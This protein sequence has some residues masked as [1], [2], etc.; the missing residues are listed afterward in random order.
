MPVGRPNL[1]PRCFMTS[2]LAPFRSL[3]MLVVLA[4]M[5]AS[6]LE[7]AEPSTELVKQTV[8]TVGGEA[9][10]LKLFRMKELLVLGSDPEKKGSPRVTVVEPPAHWWQGTKDRVTVDKE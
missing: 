10:I 6:A 8:D 1:F 9:K 4:A 3:S 5:S 2:L 7:A